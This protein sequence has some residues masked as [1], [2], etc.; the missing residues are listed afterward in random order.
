MNNIGAA[1]DPY[2]R[3]KHSTAGLSNVFDITAN[4]GRVIKGVAVFVPAQTYLRPR[5]WIWEPSWDIDRVVLSPDPEGD[6]DL[7]E[8]ADAIDALRL[9]LGRASPGRIIAARMAMMAITTSS[10][11]RVKPFFVLEFFSYVRV[12]FNFSFGDSWRT[13]PELHRLSIRISKIS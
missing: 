1:L 13:L 6:A 11:I 8:V 7:F 10:S 4:T 2:R 12:V 3:D 9:A 5:H